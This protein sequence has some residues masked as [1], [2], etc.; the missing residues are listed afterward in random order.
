MF[1]GN[2]SHSDM[3]TDIKKSYLEVDYSISLNFLLKAYLEQKFENS[4]TLDLGRKFVK[5]ISSQIVCFT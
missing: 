5:Y 3:K 2:V 1:Q 4:S